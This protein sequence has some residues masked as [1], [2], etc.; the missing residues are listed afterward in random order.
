MLLTTRAQPIS[1]GVRAWAKLAH[2]PSLWTGA[3]QIYPNTHPGL[4]HPA[5]RPNTYSHRLIIR[6]ASKI[7]VN[8]HTLNYRVTIDPILPTACKH[9]HAQQYTT[10]RS[11]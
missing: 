10:Y 1:V 11:Q 8:C 7:Y 4:V 6:L 9:T 3:H 2:C 5:C